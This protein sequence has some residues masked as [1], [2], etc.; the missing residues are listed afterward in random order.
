[1]PQSVRINGNV[2]EIRIGYLPNTGFFVMMFGLFLVVV[3]Y[4]VYENREYEK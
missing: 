3:I 1:M 2:V 4:S